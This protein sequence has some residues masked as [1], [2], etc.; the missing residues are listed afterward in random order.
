MQLRIVKKTTLENLPAGKLFL[1]DGTIALKS[2]YYSEGGSV[3]AY[4]VGSGERFWGGVSTAEEL[5]KLK[6][7]QLK[8]KL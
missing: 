1:Y 3:E 6:V 2:E 8:L 7:F 5:N 4:I